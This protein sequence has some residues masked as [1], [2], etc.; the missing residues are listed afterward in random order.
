MDIQAVESL[1]V[2]V[3]SSISTST[4]TSGSTPGTINISVPT[5]DV[6]ILEGS[7][8][9]DTT[10]QGTAGD[11]TIDAASVNA[12][13]GT[14][15]STSSGG[16]SP[17]GSTPAGNA[18]SITIESDT[19]AIFD[20]E[21]LISSSSSGD[22]D[23]GEVLVNAD[24]VALLAGST[25]ESRT[26][27]E[28]GFAVLGDAS[29]GSVD[30]QA[31]ESLT[32][33]ADSTISTST[34]TSGST[35]GTINIAVPAGDVEILE[36]SIVSD[37]TGSGNAGN[38]TIETVDLTLLEG[39][40]T[41]T[42]SSTGDSS[43]SGVAGN[44]NIVATG[45]STLTDQSTISS[46]SLGTGDAGTVSIDTG[47][48][49]V[50]GES[51]IESE[52]TLGSGSADAGSVD[53]TVAEDLVLSD[54][55]VIT[56][57]TNTFGSTVGTVTITMPNGDL[58]IDESEIATV[59][60]S[61]TD[62][63]VITIDTNSLQISNGLITSSTEGVNGE[64]GVDEAGNAGVVVITATDEARLRDG[65]QISSSSSGDGNADQVTLIAGTVD[66]GG[67][68]SIDSE[69]TAE[70][71]DATAGMVLVNSQE[72]ITLD[73]RSRISTSAM[74]DGL[75]G[76][77]SLIATGDVR[78][79][80]QSEVSSNSVGNGAA[81]EI[82]VTAE[83]LDLSGESTINS[84][85]I[86]R[87][88]VVSTADA[89]TV[90][91]AVN[92]NLFLSDRSAIS[93]NTATQGSGSVT[94]AGS[95][96]VV[97][98]SVDLSEGEI[99]SETT[100]DANAG[101]VDI[102]ASGDLNVSL[103]SRISSSSSSGGDA[104]SVT[105]EAQNL[106][107]AEQSTI[108]SST[109]AG[110]MGVSSA[111][112]GE[113]TVT[114]VE[115]IIISGKSTI[116]TSTETAGSEIG[117]I[118]IDA[119]SVVV[120]ESSINSETSGTA[121]AGTIEITA[122]ED[123]SLSVASGISSS[124]S[125]DGSAGAVTVIAKDVELTAESS[126]DSQTT[127]EIDPSTATNA[128][129]VLVI[130]RERLFVS[131][132]SQITTDTVTQGDV[133]GSVEVQSP[134]ID[135]VNGDI[136]SS[137]SGSGDAGEITI[138]NALRDEDGTF[139]QRGNLAVTAGGSIVS[140]TA[141]SGAPGSVEISNSASIS[142][143]SVPASQ[144]QISTESSIFS[145][146]LNSGD[147]KIIDSGELVISGGSSINLQSEGGVNAGDVEIVVE[148]L[149]L[150]DANITSSAIG[151]DQ[152]GQDAGNAGNIRIE[153]TGPT[154]IAGESQ[155]LSQSVGDGNAGTVSIKAQSLDISGESVIESTTT[156]ATATSNAGSVT[157]LVKDDVN[158]SGESR[159]STSTAAANQALEEGQLEPGAIS[160]DA[161][162]INIANAEITSETT[163]GGPAGT[164]EIRAAGEAVLSQNGRISSSTSGTGAAGSVDL[165]AQS[166]SLSGESVIESA[167][168]TNAVDVTTADAG[169]VN[170]LAAENI[171]VADRSSI[172]TNTTTDGA[173]GA[174][175]VESMFGDVLVTDSS[176]TGET[177]RGANAGSVEVLATSGA[178]AIT[179]SGSISSSSS[180]DGNAGTVKVTADTITVNSMS[181]IASE[182]TGNA[183]NTASAGDV[184]V[185]GQESVMVSD[186]GS[187][188][189]SSSTNGAVAGNITVASGDIQV[190]NGRINS[191]TT[192]PGPAGELLVDNAIV[193]T[194]ERGSLLVSDG[195]QITSGTDGFGNPGTVT[196]ENS[197]TIT[198]QGIDTE[199]LGLTEEDQTEI[200]TR[201]GEEAPVAG[202]TGTGQVIIRNS[203]TLS[204]QDAAQITGATTGARDGGG[205]DLDIEQLEM[206]AG[207]ITSTTSAAGSAG[208][209]NIST[210]G[211][212]TADADSEVSTTAEEGSSGSAGSIVVTAADDVNIF[213]T[214]EITSN[215]AGSGGTGSITINA[216]SLFID[217]VRAE[218]SDATANQGNALLLGD[219]TTE[220]PEATEETDEPEPRT[221]IFSESTG[222]GDEA[223]PGG[224]IEI[225][226]ADTL[227][228]RNTGEISSNAT[229]DTNL[230]GSINIFTDTMSIDGTATNEDGTNG[231]GITATSAFNGATGSGGDI[232][233]QGVRQDEPGATAP[234]TAV[235]LQNGANISASSS[236]SGQ[237]GEITV[238]ALLIDLDNST[239]NNEN[240]SNDV[241]APGSSAGGRITLGHF[242][243]DENGEPL[244]DEN[245][246]PVLVD[247][248]MIIVQNGSQVSTSSIIGNSGD[249]TLGADT[250]MIKRGL[251]LS[252]T[253]EG[254][255]AAGN[256]TLNSDVLALDQAFVQAN[257][258][259]GTGGLIEVN[260]TITQS[261]GGVNVGGD[262][263]DPPPNFND[264]DVISSSVIQAA[265]ASGV[266]GEVRLSSPVFDVNAVVNDLDSDF[267]DITDLAIDPCAAFVEGA[268]SSLTTPGNGGLPLVGSILGTTDVTT[269]LLDI[270]DD[271]TESAPVD[272][273]KKK[274]DRG[275]LF[276]PA[277]GDSQGQSVFSLAD[278]DAIGHDCEGAY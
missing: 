174:L 93:T 255:A 132:E 47:S 197:E 207:L 153:T 147:I 276:V 52:T 13:Q 100:G 30:I 150:I 178:V 64:N 209:I 254:S 249:V 11:V 160:I 9:S 105:I 18:G 20:D 188:S 3:D 62:A 54:N 264:G 108:T 104:G 70:G 114:T 39:Q 55:S 58:L 225:N 115:D 183:E 122:D 49:V 76:Q 23:A 135:L 94:D 268:P 216:T 74:S 138:D 113:V 125:G 233:I 266:T 136:T 45:D 180:G 173:G 15:T 189:V 222:A 229:G 163:G 149:E 155:I 2:G 77:V 215:A 126:I 40:V 119:R 34:A 194:A 145:N 21:T 27:G 89:G 109:V 24:T 111:S 101:E 65:S 218:D 277:D 251:I 144:G 234:A 46:S 80:S 42:T 112:A 10:G 130:A 84:S 221:G 219:E 156:L 253:S 107:V 83:S 59:T 123:V 116:S 259:G 187:I 210:S 92:D 16:D 17:S 247:D 172:S 81:G 41:S 169:N 166:V 44:I 106:V 274:I 51:R 99:T 179:D 1:T 157:I 146:A 110:E 248:T 170:V 182:T 35:P 152:T 192:G 154:V 5:G 14:I 50:T 67:E 164:I 82:L 48:L 252:S 242:Q 239:I 6:D 66:L 75:A 230:A 186:Q 142:L 60:T 272:N 128:G 265:S 235:L 267:I 203:G 120:V 270:L 231:S 43:L 97:A 201:A 232:T 88:G 181:T 86:A 103:S 250:L 237:A 96:S 141:G 238:N 124:S 223:K 240:S 33:G 12:V 191:D 26:T 68:S 246:E 204:I 8:V 190:T 185:T 79:T 202:A 226:L 133:V 256:I 275:F 171:T 139:I 273:T 212:V 244:R 143:A 200:S 22:G 31:V 236:G 36:G 243:L 102:K 162:N 214:S 131:G 193:G 61:D 85:A 159:I 19:D 129:N 29:A 228:L 199:A 151:E 7:I 4:T 211:S 53:I 220:S 184:E 224:E 161:T 196:I 177:S 271:F 260:T 72:D 263:V 167:T 261:S 206:S 78:L 195:G 69:V 269:E 205:I 90:T 87:D 91:I 175:R 95:I 56:A 245:G 28:E 257:A 127:E 217:G 121:A 63:G 165:I 227:D 258:N 278:T 118:D 198:L 134:N 262:P 148:S 32:V 140:G 213:N 98:A 57:S 158:I 168:T 71:G 38:V 208:S 137:T 117:S 176:I 37:T 241:S 25:I 73:G